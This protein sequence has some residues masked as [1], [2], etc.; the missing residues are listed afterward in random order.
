MKVVF[1]PVLQG[2]GAK[3]VYTSRQ[4]VADSPIPF[5]PLTELLPVVDVLSLHL[6]LTP[7]TTGMIDA[8]AF[9]AMKRGGG[10]PKVAVAGRFVGCI[11]K[12]A[13]SEEASARSARW[14][15]AFLV[16]EA[17]AQACPSTTRQ[18]NAPNASG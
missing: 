5:L 9:A 12:R 7:E 8:A 17:G 16:K 13:S 3:V 18:L 4:R 11:P 1:V 14:R 10:S 2:I 15:R 6:P